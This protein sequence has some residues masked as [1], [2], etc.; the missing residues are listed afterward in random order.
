MGAGPNSG[1]KGTGVLIG[2]D[3]LFIYYIIIFAV[4]HSG[5]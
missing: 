1:N 2:L 5:F 4:K 3:I